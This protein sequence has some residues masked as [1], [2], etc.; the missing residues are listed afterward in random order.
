MESCLTNI[1][2]TKRDAENKMERKRKEN[3]KRKGKAKPVPP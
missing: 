1:H 2:K 3:G